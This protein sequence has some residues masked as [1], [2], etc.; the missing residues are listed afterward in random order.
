MLSKSVLLG[1]RRKKGVMGGTTVSHLWGGA[2]RDA[3]LHR[4]ECKSCHQISE[5]LLPYLHLTLG[6]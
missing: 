3:V 2:T 1:E 4:S 6:P 5:K